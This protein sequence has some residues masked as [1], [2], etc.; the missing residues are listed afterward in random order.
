MVTE[1]P[2]EDRTPHH[3]RRSG[4][5]RRA[6][7]KASGYIARVAAIPAG[8]ARA[9]TEIYRHFQVTYGRGEK[10]ASRAVTFGPSSTLQPS[11]RS[12]RRTFLDLNA[13]NMWGR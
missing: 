3:A 12:A 10:S 5:A 8:L 6:A 7:G 11:S 13:T 1:V 4:T 2:R 9:G